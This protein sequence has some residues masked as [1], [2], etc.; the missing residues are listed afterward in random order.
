MIIKTYDNIHRKAVISI[1]DYF[2]NK[3]IINFYYDGYQDYEWKKGSNGI[4]CDIVDSLEKAESKA[5]RYIKK[6]LK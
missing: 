1:S 2:K 5:Q 6:D 3:Y 4:S